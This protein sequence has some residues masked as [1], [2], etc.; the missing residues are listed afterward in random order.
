VLVDIRLPRTPARLVVQSNEYLDEL[1]RELELIRLGRDQRAGSA[2]SA[3]LLALIDDILTRFAF[4]HLGSQEQAEAALAAGAEEVTVELTLPPEAAAAG[5]DFVRLIDEAAA[6]AERGELLTL[7]PAPQVATF[8]RE[9]VAEVVRRVRDDT[10]SSAPFEASAEL[11]GAAAAPR[12][13]PPAPD[14]ARTHP[15]ALA[16][17][18][19]TLPCEP[20][21]P[22]RGR[23]WL[24]DVLSDW[25]VEAL[26]DVAALPTSELITNAV[27]HAR[28]PLTVSLALHADVLHVEVADA[29]PAPVAAFPHDLDAATGR[30]LALVAALSERWG[31]HAQPPGKA[32]WF[33][34][35]PEG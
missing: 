4:A 16:S 10:A 1:L 17:A 24:Q 25:G 15:P 11:A 29:S 30:G 35:R 7:P 28:T 13:T 32:V 8:I 14:R 27:L 26:A 22:T 9:W 18:S 34:V 23:R 19:L 21:A 31:V 2:Q 20:V 5:E 6:L 12:R 33:D 3:R